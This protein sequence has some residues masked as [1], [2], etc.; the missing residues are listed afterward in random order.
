MKD[1]R[2]GARLRKE[3]VSDSGDGFKAG[4]S[5]GRGEIICQVC[6]PVGFIESKCAVPRVSGRGGFDPATLPL[7][8]TMVKSLHS[9]DRRDLS[10]P[11]ES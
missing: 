11:P 9:G 2:I 5:L 7:P 10:E 3:A 4:D 6:S 8:G 1:S